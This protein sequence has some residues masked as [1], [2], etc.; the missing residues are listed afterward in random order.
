[1]TADGLVDQSIKYF[2]DLKI[3]KYR[4]AQKN[5]L[6]QKLLDEIESQGVNDILAEVN[7]EEGELF[8]SEDE[9]DEAVRRPVSNP[10]DNIIVTE[11]CLVCL[12]ESGADGVDLH[13]FNFECG[14]RFCADCIPRLFNGRENTTCAFCRAPITMQAKRRVFATDYVV[15]SSQE[16]PTRQ[17]PR[18]LTPE[19]RRQENVLLMAS[20]L[21][22]DPAEAVEPV[23]DSDT[24]LDRVIAEEEED[25]EVVFV[26]AGKR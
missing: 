20:R 17:A 13:F 6:L 8:L 23:D 2:V 7:A 19:E 25:E 18:V 21:N 3:K 16:E 15:R 26:E 4:K 1:M 11:K 5:K 10:I 9:D 24:E 14:H 22:R 12:N